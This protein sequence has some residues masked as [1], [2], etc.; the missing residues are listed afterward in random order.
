MMGAKGAHKG[1]GR[2]RIRGDWLPRW[3]KQF[4]NRLERRRTKNCLDSGQEPPPRNVPQGDAMM[5]WDN[6]YP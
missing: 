6:F 1:K 2:Y 5:K 3:I 4:H